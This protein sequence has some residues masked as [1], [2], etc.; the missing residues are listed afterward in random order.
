MARS[1]MRRQELFDVSKFDPKDVERYGVHEIGRHMLQARKM[2]EAGVTSANTPTRP[3]R[4]RRAPVAD[5]GRDSLWVYLRRTESFFPFRN[6]VLVANLIGLVGYVLLPTAPP[7]RRLKTLSATDFTP[8]S[9]W[10]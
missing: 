10:T 6:T 5:E 8:R 7:L 1:L 3:L 2:L 4:K 9:S